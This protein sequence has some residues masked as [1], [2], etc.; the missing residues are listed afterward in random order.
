MQCNYLAGKILLM[1]LLL[2]YGF[3]A[4]AEQRSVPVRVAVVRQMPVQKQITLP[5]QIS[6]QRISSLSSRVD[7]MVVAVRVEEGDK[8]KKGDV[9]IKLDDQLSRYDV[10]RSAAALE[11]AR[12]RLSESKRQRSE[13]SKLV[14]N[15]FIA[16]SSFEAAE[17]NV[18]I[19]AA[20]VK[21]LQ[22]EYRRNQELLSRHEI[23]AP[24]DGVV[25]E[26]RVEAGQWIKV[27]NSV[28]TLVDIYHLRVEV[29]VPQRFFSQLALTTKV[30]FVPDALLPQQQISASISQIIPVANETSHNFPV[31]IKFDNDSNQLTSGMTVRVR[32]MPESVS[33]TESLLIPR[34]AIVKQPDN[35][36][37][38]WVLKKLQEG[39]QVHPVTVTTGRVANNQVEIVSGQLQKGDQVVIRGNEILKPGQTVRVIP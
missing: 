2:F 33:Q 17:S 9:L 6:S 24:F 16:N 21:R 28:L 3:S 34:D 7:A 15:K 13:F 18:R 14:D 35:K 26:K 25:S 37:Q 38:V 22:A 32:L 36:Q 8:V 10:S 5:G 12:A 23:K 19:S 20:I 30:L 11:E 1:F 39:Y 27:G 29:A 4:F 31:H